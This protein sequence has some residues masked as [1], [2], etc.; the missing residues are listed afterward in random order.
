M[1]FGVSALK[2]IKHLVAI[3]INLASKEVL[4]TTKGRKQLEILLIVLLMS[5]RAPWIF[6]R[7]STKLII[8]L[9]L[10]KLKKRRLPVT[11]KLLDML[12]FWFGNCYSC[13][14]FVISILFQ[15]FQLKFGI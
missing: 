2:T 7:L 9:F 6:L 12:T 14:K 5:I 1:E 8:A 3:L 4:V 11:G 10:T 13:V 15:F